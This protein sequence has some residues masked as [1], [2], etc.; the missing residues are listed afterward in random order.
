VGMARGPDDA[1]TARN[2]DRLVRWNRDYINFNQLMMIVMTNL[3][4]TREK[5]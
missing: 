1:R 2:L 5:L 3:I 4:C